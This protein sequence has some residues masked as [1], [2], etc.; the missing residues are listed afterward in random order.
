MALDYHDLCVAWGTATE[1]DKWPAPKRDFRPLAMPVFWTW[2]AETAEQAMSLIRDDYETGRDM[3]VSAEGRRYFCRACA[4]DLPPYQVFTMYTE[5]GM[6]ELALRGE[7][8]SKEYGTATVMARRSVVEA[9]AQVLDAL[10]A[11]E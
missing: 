7:I 5:L 3:A 4:M 9:A 8:E 6:H 10:I 2:L 11:E 1:R